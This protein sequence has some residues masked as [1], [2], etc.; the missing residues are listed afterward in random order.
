MLLILFRSTCLHSDCALSSVRQTISQQ[1]S[2]FYFN[3][4]QLLSSVG[5]EKCKAKVHPRRGNEGPEEESKCSSTLSLIWLLDGGGFQ[6]HGPTAA[7]PT[8]SPVSPSTE[9]RVGP[10]FSREECGK[11]R[12]TTGFDP[13][14]V[15]PVASSYAD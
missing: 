14:T 13:R 1:F 12:P 8:N 3:I 11:L 15:R 6:R 10:R 2:T 9:G 7:P 5:P 4:T